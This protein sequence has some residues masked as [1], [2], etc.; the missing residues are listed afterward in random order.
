M[1]I[2]FVRLI[3]VALPRLAE[4]SSS[5]SIIALAARCSGWPQRLSD[6]AAS[7][8]V[9]LFAN[10]EIKSPTVESTP[11]ALPSGHKLADAIH[12]TA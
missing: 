2:V 3:A 7:R 1:I 12:A 11:Y 9:E 8:I 4:A 6:C 5:S 10:R